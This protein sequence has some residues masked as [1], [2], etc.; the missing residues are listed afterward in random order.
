MLG[1]VEQEEIGEPQERFELR[2]SRVGIGVQPAHSLRG[3]K[4]SHT[5]LRRTIRLRFGRGIRVPTVQALRKGMYPLMSAFKYFP[6]D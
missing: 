2:L 5:L 6:S 3:S 1:V 4:G